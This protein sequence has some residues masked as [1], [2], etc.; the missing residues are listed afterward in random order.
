V[1]SDQIAPHY[2]EATGMRLLA[3]RDLTAHDMLQPPRAALVNQAMALRFFGSSDVVGR[4]FLWGDE[5]TGVPI[6]IVGV[7]RDAAYNA[8]RQ[9]N[10]V[11]VYFPLGPDWQ[12]PSDAC[13]VVRTAG[14][15]PG[16]AA[17][18]REQLHQIAPGVAIRSMDWVQAAMDQSLAIERMVAWIAGLF[19]ALALVLACLGLYGMMSYVAARR[20]HEIGIRVSLGATPAVVSRMVLGDALGLGFAGVLIGIPAALL[21]SRLVANLL[22]GIA[23]TDAPT[24]AASALLLLAVVGLAAW[25]PAWRASRVD[26][27]RALRCE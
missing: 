7:V 16:I 26:A 5:A 15:A 19:G 17:Q 4:R 8:L 6:E 21:G 13:L 2:L 27:T 20:T 11:M 24:L 9:P 18:I 10:A 22:F 23:A 3:G 14:D 12:D 1:A 25:L